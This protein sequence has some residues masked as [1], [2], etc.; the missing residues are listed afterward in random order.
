MKNKKV[1]LDHF[2]THGKMQRSCIFKGLN[3][4]DLCPGRWH[5]V[6]FTC[7]MLLGDLLFKYIRVLMVSASNEI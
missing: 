3:R 7:V 2:L 4:R 6:P 5:I 1:F